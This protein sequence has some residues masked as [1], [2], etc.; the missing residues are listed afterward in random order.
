MA[1]KLFSQ[2]LKLNN[3][4]IH[5]LFSILGAT[6]GIL[7]HIPLIV[8]IIK[9]EKGYSFTSFALWSILDFIAARNIYLQNSDYLL[10][11]VWGACA[12]SMA[13]L[14]FIKKE[15][16][17]SY[18]ETMVIILI[19]ITLTLWYIF[20]S[21]IA[22]IAT[23]SSLIIAS[24]PQIKDTFFRPSI[25]VGRVYIMFTLGALFSIFS[26]NE[27]S[28]YALIYPVTAMILCGLIMIFSYRK[29]QV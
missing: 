3:M 2:N 29:I 21:K 18:V 28:L 24:I 26:A 16:S 6:I 10:A 17:W 13:I 20:G 15:I 19:S 5:K 11:L 9:G 22:L 23:I 4:E 27:I 1:L 25:K 14:L 7:A 8:D 12:G